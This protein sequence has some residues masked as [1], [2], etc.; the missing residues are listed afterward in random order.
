[1]YIYRHAAQTLLE[2]S[3]HFGAVLV[4]GP[5]QVGK[6]TLIK[7]T[8][9]K[10]REAKVKQISLDDPLSLETALDEGGRFFQDHK[11]PV[12]IDEIQYAPT[13]FPY[14]KMIVDAEN[15]PG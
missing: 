5:R 6:T 8:I 2:L 11:P 1:M 15:K 14:I 7:E 3:R 4:T 9:I 10:S 12:F 13:L